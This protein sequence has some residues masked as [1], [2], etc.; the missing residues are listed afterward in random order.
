MAASS[1]LR[2]ETLRYEAPPMKRGGREVPMFGR[3]PWRLLVRAA[4]L[5]A[6][7]AACSS[8]SDKPTN[9]PTPST[10]GG[11]A[12]TDGAGASATQ[13][14]SAG[15]SSGG[16]ATATNTESSA[17][18]NGGSAAGASSGGSGANTGSS[19]AGAAGGSNATDAG[20]A[21]AA[22][23]SYANVVAVTPSGAAGSYTFNVSVESSDVDCSEF[24]DWWEVVSD[25][26]IL[27]Y[28]RILEHSHTDENGS[29][30][31]DAPGNTFTRSGGPVDVLA[32]QV[33]IVRAHISTLDHYQGSAMRGSVTEG[34]VIASDVD[35]AFAADLESAAP[36]PESCDF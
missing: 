4:L 23:E 22:S 27:L 5:A 17:G 21:G 3:T 1:R 2:Y 29:S 36:Q 20:G 30:D 12:A 33:V 14:S 11:G 24:A 9:D 26:G 15:G 10:D 8:G 16:P 19:S 32:D 31:A 18:G 35:P 13:G 25:D 7:F 28:R 6:P 34:F